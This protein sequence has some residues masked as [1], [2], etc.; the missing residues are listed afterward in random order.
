MKIAPDPIYASEGAKRY[1]APL[2]M[3]DSFALTTQQE[4]DVGPHYLNAK[5]RG[6]I[7]AVALISVSLFWQKSRLPQIFVATSMLTFV[8]ALVLDSDMTA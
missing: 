8:L 5:A 4:I 7:W 3:T 1:Y 6:E 2:I